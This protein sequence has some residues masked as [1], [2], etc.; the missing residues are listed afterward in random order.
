MF[1]GISNVLTWYSFT[2]ILIAM[3]SAKEVYEYKTEV[4]V[5]VFG[6]H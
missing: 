5:L 4:N 3:D 1:G 2:L 6:L